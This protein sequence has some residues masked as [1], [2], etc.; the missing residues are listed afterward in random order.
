MLI[1]G[2]HFWMSRLRP[3]FQQVRIPALCLEA[4]VHAVYQCHGR[5]WTVLCFPLGTASCNFDWAIYEYGVWGFFCVGDA[6][7]KVIQ[8]IFPFRFCSLALLSGGDITLL[9]S[10]PHARSKVNLVRPSSSC[11]KNTSMTSDLL[12]GKNLSH[13]KPV[14]SWD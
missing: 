1:S 14:E 9:L 13:N 10:H 12:E 6:L 5:F 3:C 2:C 8:V 11:G 4:A 7:T